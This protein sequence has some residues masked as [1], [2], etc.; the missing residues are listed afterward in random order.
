MATSPCVCAII[1]RPLLLLLLLLL[2]AGGEA[3]LVRTGLRPFRGWTSWDLSAVTYKGYGHG[4]LNS[5]N[6][7]AQSAALQA[8]GLQAHGFDH[9]NIDSFWSCNPMQTVDKWGRWMTNFS[10]FPDG[11]AA[12]AKAI[13]ARGQKFGLCE[14][15][16]ARDNYDAVQ[17]L[18][19]A[20]RPN[21][22][23]NVLLQISTLVFYRPP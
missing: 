10:R 13:H 7:L 18:S 20:L 3:K 22:A 5:S 1:M 11:M 17:P 15:R 23:P 16:C 2:A 6:V 12:V 19:L 14:Q 9:V 8:T 4:W 21:Y